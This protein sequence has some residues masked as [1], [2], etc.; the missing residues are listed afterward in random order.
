[1]I[2]VPT[3]V[4]FTIASPIRVLLAPDHP[5]LFAFIRRVCEETGADEPRAV[6]VVPHVNAGVRMKTSFANLFVPPKKDPPAGIVPKKEETPVTAVSLTFD[7]DIKPIFRAKCTSCHGDPPK[8]KKPDG[9]LDLRTMMAI[10]A[11]GNSGGAG[12][13]PKSLKDSPIWEQID[14]GKMPPPNKD[15]LTAKETQMIRDWIVRGAN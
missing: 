11:G 2:I 4:V 8:D 1:M 14:E 13:I 9:G 10:K 6:Y 15:K 5:Q 12:A 7:K 3:T